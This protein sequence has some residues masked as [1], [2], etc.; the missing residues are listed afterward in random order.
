MHHLTMQIL[1]IIKTKLTKAH[2]PTLKITMSPETI[3]LTS[4][5]VIYR[6]F[7]IAILIYLITMQVLKT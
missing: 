4:T 3:L 5:K 1:Q 2:I 6:H 7:Q